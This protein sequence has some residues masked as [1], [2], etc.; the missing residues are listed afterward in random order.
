[1]KLALTGQ[2]AKVL[3]SPSGGAGLVRQSS[4]SP[5]GSL[6]T[7]ARDSKT[8]NSTL[9]DNPSCREILYEV[10]R[11]DPEKCSGCLDFR[12]GRRQCRACPHRESRP[13]RPAQPRS[14]GAG[15]PVA[16]PPVKVGAR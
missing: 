16:P 6:V 11:P 13:S 9:G 12:V 1:M 8:L 4:G 3:P 15:P 10:D 7:C 5:R 2:M 14:G